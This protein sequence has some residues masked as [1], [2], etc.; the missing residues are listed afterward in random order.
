MGEQNFNA[1]NYLFSIAKNQNHK[2]EIKV[3][4][5]KKLED[6]KKISHVLYKGF[7]YI[8]ILDNNSTITLEQIMNELNSD[9]N[10][11]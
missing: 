9:I 6:S 8:D 7:S 2:N 11:I 4:Y 3:E 5:Y 10:N 1:N